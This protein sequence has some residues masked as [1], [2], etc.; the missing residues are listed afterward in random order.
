MA[1]PVGSLVKGT[2]GAGLLGGG[3]TT[4]TLYENTK[5]NYSDL[6]SKFEEIVVD[7]IQKDHQAQVLKYQRSDSITATPVTLKCV[8]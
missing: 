5:R 6:I 7:E 4:G 1:I 3:I 8:Y 2:V